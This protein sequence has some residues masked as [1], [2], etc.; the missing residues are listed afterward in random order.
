MALMFARCILCDE[1]HALRPD[2]RMSIHQNARGERCPGQLATVEPTPPPA[3]STRP[4]RVPVPERDEPSELEL[5]AAYA[6]EGRWKISN[7]SDPLP[8]VDRRIY[9]VKGAYKV[10]GGLPTLGRR[11]R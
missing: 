2:R 1:D 4:P 6:W 3:K 7:P 9:A 8:P 11:R 10:S 5:A